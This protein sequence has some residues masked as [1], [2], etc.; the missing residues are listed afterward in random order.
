MPKVATAEGS[1]RI[2]NEMFAAII[3]RNGNVRLNIIASCA[4][5]EP[6]HST[7]PVRYNRNKPSTLTNHSQGGLTTT[8]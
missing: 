1:D 2:P 4:M 7:V 6:T 3:T 5:Y 8:S